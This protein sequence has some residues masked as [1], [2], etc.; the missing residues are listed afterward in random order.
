MF[1]PKRVLAVAAVAVIAPLTACGSPST[2]TP[3][4]SMSI[5]PAPAAGTILTAAQVKDI[6]KAAG[7]NLTSVHETIKIATRAADI[8]GEG[9]MTRAN[10]TIAIQMTMTVPQLGEMQ[11]RLVG[12]AFYI[13]MNLPQLGGKWIKIDLTD[14]NSPLGQ[15]LGSVTAMSPSQ[16]FDQYSGGLIGGTFLGT[17]TIGDHYV[18][19]VDTASA[20]KHLPAGMATNSLIQKGM[21]ALPKSIKLN[22][23]VKGGLLQQTVVDMGPAGTVTVTLSDFGKTVDVVAPPTAEVTSIP[24]LG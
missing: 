13:K 11:A 8:T 2:S 15:M 4:L 24:G 7:A 19:N 5:A 14:K 21:K 18:I 23:W 20:A 22:V 3:G 16:M 9:D 12:Q 6:V 10:G 1:A 17:D